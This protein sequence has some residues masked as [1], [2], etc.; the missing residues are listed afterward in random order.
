MKDIIWLL[1]LAVIIL[2]PA[3]AC[4]PVY[5]AH[6]ATYHFDRSVQRDE[7]NPGAYARCGMT[8]AG[9]YRNSWGKG[10]AYLAATAEWGPIGLSAGVVTGY[11][12]PSP[13]LIATVRLPAGL[14][15]GIFPSHD[16]KSGGIHLLKDF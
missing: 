7:I 1:C 9:A 3:Q 11:G 16:G 12:K 14:R 13:L 6:L 10:S 2:L 15:L 4:E 8:V 5:G